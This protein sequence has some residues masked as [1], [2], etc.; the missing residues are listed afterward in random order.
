MNTVIVRRGEHQV[1][2]DPL[3]FWLLAKSGQIL[4]SD[5]I[6]DWKSKQFLPAPQFADVAPFLPPKS[7]GEI[8][9]DIVVGALGVG[10]VFV[11]GAG[12]VSLLESIFAAPEPAAK[13][14]SREPNYEPLET[15][16]KELVRARDNETCSYCGCYAP[17]GHVDHKTS[18]KNGG[19][20]LL[21][22]LAWA[23]GSCNCSKGRMNAPQ[24]RKLLLN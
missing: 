19:S 8:I 18:R 9:E 6:F 23:C 24:F 16:K 5:L 17:Q 20:N 2:Y 7:L 1:G 15:W 10:V 13:R 22:N 12:A 11:V 3:A 14:K 21:R 4:R